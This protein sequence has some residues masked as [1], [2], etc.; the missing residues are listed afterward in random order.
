M[1]HADK[2]ERDADK[3]WDYFYKRNED[4]FF[5]DRHYFDR[6]FP[7]LFK[8]GTVLEVGLAEVLKGCLCASCGSPAGLV[9]VAAFTYQVPHQV[10]FSRVGV[11][12]HAGGEHSP[13]HPVSRH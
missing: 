4:R 8:A 10:I 7:E 1:R 5:K 9:C 6:E 12:L 2:Y 11:R 13:Q 3:Y